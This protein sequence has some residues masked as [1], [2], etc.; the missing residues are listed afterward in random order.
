MAY[1]WLGEDGTE[2]IVTYGQLYR[3]VCRFSNGLKSLGV[4]K[5]DR[6][7]IYMPLTLEGVIAMLACARIGAIHSVVYAG[8]GHS[9]L[10]DR[11]T[12]A[13]AKVIIAGDV[14]F[15]R[16]KT[17]PLKPIVDEALDGIDFVQHVVVFSRRA[18][19]LTRGRST[20][21]N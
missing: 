13:Q 2:R 19:E 15:R 14:G 11:I 1:I 21:A 5:G 10:R 7:V 12:D 17:V 8:L 6:V 9:A 3:Q 20:T 4:G 18:A 16:G